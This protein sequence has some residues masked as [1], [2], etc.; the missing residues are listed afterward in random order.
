MITLASIIALIISLLTGAPVT[1]AVAPSNYTSQVGTVA[2]AVQVKADNVHHTA[3]EAEPTPEART[4]NNEYVYTDT[5]VPPF[6]G[7]ELIGESSSQDFDGTVSTSY[8]WR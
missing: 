4:A 3:E 2:T 1:E 5:D 7:A 8:I 6:E